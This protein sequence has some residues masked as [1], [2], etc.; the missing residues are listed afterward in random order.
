[1]RR[2]L[3]YQFKTQVKNFNWLDRKFNANDL[4]VANLKEELNDSFTDI[5]ENFNSKKTDSECYNVFMREDHIKRTSAS[6]GGEV[7]ENE[8]R[9]MLNEYFDLMAGQKHYYI[10]EF[11]EHE[12]LIRKTFADRFN[13]KPDTV[14][15]RVQVEVPG[16]YFIVH[17]D[18]N[19]F[20][21]WDQEPEMRYDKVVEQQ[22]H[23]IFVTFLQDQEL[24]QV[25]GFGKSTINW[26]AGDTVT[27]EHRNVPHYT[28]NVGYH[29][30]FMLVTTGMPN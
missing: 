5:I 30:N 2:W 3:E 19:R 26:S 17:I 7:S 22:Q 12:E 6:T 11:L 15:F 8:Y 24:G 25:F 20:K 27:W 13:L 23:K 28:A 18:R 9:S 4:K 14:K 1:M 16:R 29:T 10:T 21:V